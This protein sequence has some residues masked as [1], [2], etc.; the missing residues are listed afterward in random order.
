MISHSFK[1][2]WKNKRRSRLLMFEFFLSFI[3]LFAL[4]SLTGKLMHNKKIP[5]GFEYKNIWCG[6][7]EP[8]IQLN[9]DSVLI[10]KSEIFQSIKNHP[11]VLAL[12]QQENNLPFVRNRTYSNYFKFQDKVLKKNFAFGVDDDFAKV[13]NLKIVEGRWFKKEDDASML[14]PVVISKSMRDQLDNKKVVGSEAVFNQ[15]KK[16]CRIIGV[17][18]DFKYKGEYSSLQNEVFFRCSLHKNPNYSNVDYESYIIDGQSDHNQR[19][20][21]K[22]KPGAGTG[23]EGILMKELNNQFTNWKFR[24]EPLQ[25]LRSDYMKAYWFPIIIFAGISL[26]LIF[27]VVIG[28][29]AVLWYNINHRKAEI[30]I[31]IA[32]G[33]TTRH[34]YIQ[35]I[36][37]LLWIS[38]LGIIPGLIIALQF[39]IMEVFNVEA[40]IYVQSILFSIAIIF[41]LV[42]L[43]ALLP[44]YQASKIQPAIALHEE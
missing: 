30:G 38:V 15:Q 24:F 28:L 21:L 41:A 4:L 40:G 22:L 29:F 10:I 32:N 14:R 27:N 34:I 8:E 12:T 9:R 31:R 42:M 3:L 2:I 39:L 16:Q 6:I 11:E 35:F 44:C 33:A 37:E 13:F 43:S 20:Y 5:I 36:V 17:V 19:I 1:K 18:E 23:F 25:K 7:L 26:F